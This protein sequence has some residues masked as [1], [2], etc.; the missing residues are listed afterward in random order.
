MEYSLW[1]DPIYSP[2]FRTVVIDGS[3]LGPDLNGGRV[4]CMNGIGDMPLSSYLFVSGACPALNDDTPAAPTPAVFSADPTP[5]V[6]TPTLLT[7]PPV[8][9]IPEPSTV[10]LLGLSLAVAGL[11]RR[12]GQGR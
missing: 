4:V 3:E 2:P 11:W 8:A 9:A 1:A 5:L 10:A 6:G 7:A 12:R